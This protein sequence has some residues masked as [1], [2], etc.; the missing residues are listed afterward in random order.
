[1]GGKQTH[2][3]SEL[4]GSALRILGAAFFGF[5]LGSIIRGIVNY[6]VPTVLMRIKNIGLDDAQ[7]IYHSSIFTNIL[8]GAVIVF[9]TA[10]IAG[11]LAKRR[12]IIVKNLLTNK[13]GKET[14][15]SLS[16]LLKKIQSSENIFVFYEAGLPDKRTSLFKT[17][18]DK[19]N[20]VQEF[21]PLDNFKLK[22]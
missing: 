7:N 5:L 11:F 6:T 10:A 4:R 15:D 19:K 16:S 13:P 8:L 1:M 14:A 3:K 21:K 2:K 22:K 12:L 17:L 18:N 20:L 9:F